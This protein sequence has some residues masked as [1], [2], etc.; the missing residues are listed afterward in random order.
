[1]AASTDPLAGALARLAAAAPALRAALLAWYD[2]AQRPLPWRQRPDPYAVW[3][4]ETMLQQTRVAAALPYWT[5]WMERWP[6]LVDLAAADPDEVR[7]LWAGL[8]Y[9][10]RA[11][12]L[13]QAARW[14]V[15]HHGGQLPA[16]RAALLA[17]PGIGPYTAG[18]ILSIAFGRPEP[19]VDANVRRVFARWLND[20]AP[21]PTR[22]DRLARAL[23]DP[24]RP[25]DW[26]QALMELGALVCTPRRPACPR[27]PVRR[28]CAAAAAG[29]PDAVPRP[30]ARHPR[31]TERWVVAWVEH[32]GRWLLLRRPPRGRFAGLW[33][34]P[35]A[36]LPP[37]ARPSAVAQRAAAAAGVVAAPQRGRQRHR[38]ELSHVTLDLVA[39]RLRADSPIPPDGDDRRWWP[40]AALPHAP[41]PRALR[42][43]VPVPRPV[44]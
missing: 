10:R 23:L 20:P 14:V 21:T 38:A 26:N 30:R 40:A 22:L 17:L 27:C 13:H 31:P 9:Y 8:G 3:V 5:R 6:T 37:R 19:A 42:P 12:A 35:L 33:A 28:W 41:L 7:A 15:A 32:D 25:G 44:G 39:V 16:D 11:G 2:A 4:A 36:P 34:P 43:L 1:M 24:G 18:A 29:A